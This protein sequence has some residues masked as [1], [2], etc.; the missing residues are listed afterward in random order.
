MKW[1]KVFLISLTTL[2]GWENGDA[3]ETVGVF[4]EEFETIK[5]KISAAH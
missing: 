5:N 4:K 3:S 2:N 1:K